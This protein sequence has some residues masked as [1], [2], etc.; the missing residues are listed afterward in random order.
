VNRSSAKQEQRFPWALTQERIDVL[1]AVLY[2]AETV[3][4][5]V[6]PG[7]VAAERAACLLTDLRE[8]CCQHAGA[9][10]PFP[11]MPLF[12]RFDGA[13]RPADSVQEAAR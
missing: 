13:D 7:G 1:A 12:P 3:F 5:N 2:K 4:G 9:A 11:D 8:A 6:E 10:D